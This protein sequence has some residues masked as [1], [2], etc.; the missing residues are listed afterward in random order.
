VIVAFVEDGRLYV[1][2]E[3]QRNVLKI[4]ARKHQHD[5]IVNLMCAR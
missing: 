3:L 5:K 1:D 4:R 2:E